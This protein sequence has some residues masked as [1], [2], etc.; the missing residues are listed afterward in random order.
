MVRGITVGLTGPER[1]YI[2]FKTRVFEGSGS[3]RCY[4]TYLKF[5]VVVEKQ[6]GDMLLLSLQVQ[7]HNGT[8]NLGTVTLVRIAE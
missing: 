7:H 8:R 5:W 3:T 1:K 4:A 2:D 6:D